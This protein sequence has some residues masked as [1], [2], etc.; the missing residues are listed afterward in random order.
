MNKL[1]TIILFGVI[2]FVTSCSKKDST[3][4]YTNFKITSIDIWNAPDPIDPLGWDPGFGNPDFFIQIKDINDNIIYDHPNY[5]SNVTSS[6]FPL[7]FECVNG[8]SITNTAATYQLQLKDWD[9]IGQNDA[10]GSISFILNNYKSGYQK[11]IYIS[12]GG[13][14]ATIHGEW[15]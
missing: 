3:P 14:E 13:L 2:L 6:D 12:T 15:Y 10:A 11:D 9:A 8:I 1:L 4:N 5:Y 7:T